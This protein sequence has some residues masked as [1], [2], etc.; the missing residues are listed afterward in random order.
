MPMIHRRRFL[1]SVVQA[2]TL[3]VLTSRCLGAAYAQGRDGG[4]GKGGDNGKGGGNDKGGSG[5]D[6]GGGKGATGASN[7]AAS[8]SSAAPTRTGLSGDLSV[9]HR[10]GMRE[11]IRNGRYEMR[12][13]Q[14]R[15][16]VSRPA[17]GADYSR[18]N[19]KL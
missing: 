5:K 4:N 8:P 17:T 13:A 2:T 14:G 10:N 6:K 3:V 15:R 1:T 18:L 7:N 19:S 11:M 16:I 9:V 12:D